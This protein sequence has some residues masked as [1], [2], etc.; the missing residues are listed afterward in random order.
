MKLTG[1]VL[2]LEREIPLRITLIDPPTGVDFCL[3]RGRSELVDVIRSS[4]ATIS[5]ELS[6]RVRASKDGAPNFLGDFVQGT[7]SDRFIY[8]NSGQRAGQAGTGWDRR[9]KVKLHGI[10]WEMIEQV[11]ATPGAILEARTPGR[12][13]DGGPCCATVPLLGGGWKIGTAHPA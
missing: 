9:A 6:V 4:G 10:T 3:Q 5:F 7:V 1:G 13:G 12:A 8:V 11:H 2:A